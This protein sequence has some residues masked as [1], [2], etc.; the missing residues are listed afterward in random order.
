MLPLVAVLL[1][2]L[3]AGCCIRALT[4]FGPLS[5]ERRDSIG[6]RPVWFGWMTGE[7]TP[8]GH[9]TRR[10]ITWWL[11]LGWVSLFAGYGVSALA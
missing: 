5:R 8:R 1:F 11:I 6:S 10:A 7:F 3:G 4:L 9:E 2:L